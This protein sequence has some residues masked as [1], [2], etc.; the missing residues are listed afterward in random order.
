MVATSSPSPQMRLACMTWRMRS[1]SSPTRSRPKSPWWEPIVKIRLPPRA[2]S[3][4]DKIPRCRQLPIFR[5]TLITADWAHD[6]FLLTDLKCGAVG[7]KSC[8]PSPVSS[9]PRR[10]HTAPL[11]RDICGERG[12][13]FNGG[14][15]SYIRKL[16]ILIFWAYRRMVSCTRVDQQ[17]KSG[18][19]SATMCGRLSG[20]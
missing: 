15:I 19:E 9:P 16:R 18:L 13:A 3:G 14:F 10:G 8:S 5:Q 17:I 20:Q 2:A 6:K 1:A 11:N 4:T 7:A 12:R